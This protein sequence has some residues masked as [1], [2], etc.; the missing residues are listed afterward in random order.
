MRE[1]H[2]AYLKERFQLLMSQTNEG[3]RGMEDKH[4]K[5]DDGA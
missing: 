1:Y 2:N 5:M 3:L 4:K